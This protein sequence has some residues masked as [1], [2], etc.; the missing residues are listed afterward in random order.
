[1][2][3]LLHGTSYLSGTLHYYSIYEPRSDTREAM[4]PENTHE[5]FLLARSCVLTNAIVSQ[6]DTTECGEKFQP[7]DQHQYIVKH[8]RIVNERGQQIY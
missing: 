6:E 1:M 4:G 5:I 2:I 3:V 7:F 8:I